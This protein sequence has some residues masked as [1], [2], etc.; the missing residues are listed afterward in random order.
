MV[1]Y[2]LFKELI[3]DANYLYNMCFNIGLLIRLDWNGLVN[4]LYSFLILFLQDLN[5]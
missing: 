3:F 2:N 1:D 5:P 4:Y